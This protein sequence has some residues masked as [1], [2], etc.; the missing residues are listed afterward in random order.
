VEPRRDRVEA[1][2]SLYSTE[3]ESVLTLK[4][5][6]NAYISEV[7]NI[8]TLKRDSPNSTQSLR[9][10][11]LN[12]YDN[13]PGI[14]ES[15]PHDALKNKTPRNFLLESKKENR[16][17]VPLEKIMEKPSFNTIKIGITKSNNI[18][19]LMKKYSIV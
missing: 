5:I 12:F 2:N 18:D 17:S 14:I 7:N 15:A 10:G 13:L 3:T 1:V 6:K 8:T 4:N 11:P 16:K 19:K 9:E